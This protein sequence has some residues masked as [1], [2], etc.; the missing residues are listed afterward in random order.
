MA[1]NFQTAIIDALYAGSVAADAAYQSPG[2]YGIP[3]S[4]VK[5]GSVAGAAITAAG[6][7]YTTVVPTVTITGDG[8]GAT[9][10]ARM[11]LLTLAINAGGTG[12][13]IGNTVTLA[14]GTFTTAAV[15][16]VTSVSGGAITGFTITNPGV[17][18]AIATS[19]TQGSTSGGGS[20]ATFQTA[21]WGVDS[22]N[23]TAAG[24]NY[25]TASIAFTLGTGSGAV[26]VAQI[27]PEGSSTASPNEQGL[28]TIIECLRGYFALIGNPQ[29]AKLAHQIISKMLSELQ[30]GAPSSYSAANN[31]S[32]ARD[33]AMQ[34]YAKRVRNPNL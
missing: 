2:T 19:L 7:G 27:N 9:A 24:T 31:A 26:A 29:E 6:S 13:A 4:Y 8:S 34:F 14:G 11:K 30:Q 10:T 28:L 18:S 25:T 20:T 32:R 17:Y 21:T 1:I 16:T 15:I 3:A 5:S 33:A 23:I 22:L 12:Y